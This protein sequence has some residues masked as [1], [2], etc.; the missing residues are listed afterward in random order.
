MG[1]FHGGGKIVHSNDNCGLLE[2]PFVDA[3]LVG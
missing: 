3:I 1:K 2:N